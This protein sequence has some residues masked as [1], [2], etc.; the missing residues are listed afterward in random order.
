MDDLYDAT[1]LLLDE[2]QLRAYEQKMYKLDLKMA[3]QAV[4]LADA[5]IEYWQ[6]RCN[7]AETLLAKT[8]SFSNS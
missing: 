5:Q 2:I 3:Q 1:K 4:A 8:Q 7:Q 6:A